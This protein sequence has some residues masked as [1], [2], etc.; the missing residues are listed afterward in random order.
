[1]A[2][3]CNPVNRVD[4]SGT[5][6]VN[7]TPGNSASDI[8]PTNFVPQEGG[9]YVPGAAGPSADQAEAARMA[10]VEEKDKKAQAE[11]EAVHQV[12]LR[13][14]EWDKLYTKEY[15][16][17][18][19]RFHLPLGTT[20]DPVQRAVLDRIGSRPLTPD[21]SAWQSNLAVALLALQIALG[22]RGLAKV[23]AAGAPH[24]SP[25]AL[26]KA[27]AESGDAQAALR[28]EATG[29]QRV[30][31]VGPKGASTTR[32]IRFNGNR[33]TYDTQAP[34][35]RKMVEFD[36]RIIR[37]RIGQDADWWTGTHGTP[38]GRFGDPDLLEG[39]FLRT[40]T[41]LGPYRGFNVKNVT[42]AT[43]DTILAP[44]TTPTVYSW[45]YS[46]CS[47]LPP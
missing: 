44:P 17:E 5:S 1:M 29:G 30:F 20:D 9:G 28:A 37:N 27:A 13:Q 24:E 2:M 45:C 23:G 22:V 43:K 31:F 8:A 4:P 35:G 11:A 36:M 46:S 18:S 25:V 21:E 26:S 34:G 41:G 42:S 6:D 40:D 15:E 32:V 7:G 47:F 3:G 38:E 33:I 14:Q 39:K 16:V 12:R 10:A 19:Q